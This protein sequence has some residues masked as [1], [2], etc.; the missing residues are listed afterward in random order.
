MAP[1]ASVQHNSGVHEQSDHS[2]YSDNENEEKTGE[3]LYETQ[4]RIRKLLSEFLIGMKFPEVFRCS[5]KTVSD[6]RV[7]RQK[8]IAA[9]KESVSA[10][11][12]ADMELWTQVHNYFY[13]KIWPLF[14]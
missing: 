7:F 14:L 9:F 3:M 13:S 5:G 8:F 2:E 1:A 4:S 11:D 12:L 6:D 10:E